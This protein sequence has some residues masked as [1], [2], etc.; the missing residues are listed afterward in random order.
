MYIK[1]K[2]AKAHE[3]STLEW[4][5]SHSPPNILSFYVFTL[6]EMS[7]SA[8]ISPFNNGFDFI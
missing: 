7:I 5:H 2:G 8:I 4:L 3:S 6:S 1:S